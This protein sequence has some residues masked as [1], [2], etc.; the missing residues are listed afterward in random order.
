MLNKSA[1]AL[2]RWKGFDQA[3]DRWLEERHDLI[4]KLSEF[5]HLRDNHVSEDARRGMVRSFTRLLIDYISAGNFEFYHRLMEEGRDNHNDQ[6]VQKAARL[7]PVIDATTEQALQF[8]EKY[9]QPANLDNLPDD[10][11][12]LAEQL[13]ALFDAEDWMI[14]H[15]HSEQIEDSAEN[16]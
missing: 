4:V 1:N 16:R 15:L 13:V 7:R 5:A 6:A 12:E 9:G 14:S 10:L 8:N 11:S 2:E 3:I